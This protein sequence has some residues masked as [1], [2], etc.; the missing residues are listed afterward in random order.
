MCTSYWTVTQ[1]CGFRVLPAQFSSNH[2]IMFVFS[3]IL[4]AQSSVAQS[5]PV[6]AQQELC[7]RQT[8]SKPLPV[9]PSAEVPLTRNVQRRYRK[10][11]YVSSHTHPEYSIFLFFQYFFLI[12]SF[13]KSRKC[14]LVYCFYSL[15]YHCFAAVKFGRMSRQQREKVVGE[16]KFHRQNSNGGS[17][18]A[19]AAA[20][21]HA[22]PTTPSRD[23]C[24][25]AAD[26]CT[27]SPT[28][29]NHFR[30]EKSIHRFVTNWLS[31]D[32]WSFSMLNGN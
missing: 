24:D 22:P 2:L 3:G 15:R 25:P 6:S 29:N 28:N 18:A 5:V 26:H 20:L 21:A 4:S 16:A 32:L 7:H 17:A 19:A 8:Q 31:L 30:W 1:S 11:K 9:L 27:A 14:I 13:C 12:C 23:M 10:Q